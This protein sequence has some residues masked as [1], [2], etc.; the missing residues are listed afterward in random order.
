MPASIR[1]TAQ[2]AQIR[3][4]F[5]F[6]FGRVSLQR[7]FLRRAGLLLFLYRSIESRKTSPPQPAGISVSKGRELARPIRA[8]S[9]DTSVH[10]A[11][12]SLFPIAAN[13]S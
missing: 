6:D 13:R 3:H 1:T 4:V 11:M 12:L 5:G 10:H 2:F 7:G 8:R 9:V